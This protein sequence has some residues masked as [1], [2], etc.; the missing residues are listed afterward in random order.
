MFIIEPNAVFLQE[1]G[2]RLS[3]DFPQL[4]QFTECM[5]SVFNEMHI[6]VIKIQMP[7]LEER[8]S[9]VLRHTHW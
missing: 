3:S 5:Y 6:P 2:V 9:L 4:V 1:D 7:D 8:I